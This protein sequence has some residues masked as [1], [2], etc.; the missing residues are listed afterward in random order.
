MQSLPP[1]LAAANREINAL[2]LTV[3]HLIARAS[4]HIHAKQL[5]GKIAW[6][7]ESQTRPGL[8]Y[9]TLRVVD[10]WSGDCC[11]CED[12]CYRRMQCKHLRAVNILSPFLPRP[13]RQR[14]HP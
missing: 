14:L 11:T 6:L 8:Y 4:K 7:V 12:F 13:S 2:N 9:T 3:R 5:D 10:G 1:S